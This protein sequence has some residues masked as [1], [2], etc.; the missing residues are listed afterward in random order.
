MPTVLKYLC[1]IVQRVNGPVAW[2]TCDEVDEDLEF[3]CHFRHEK[4][5]ADHSATKQAELATGH[6]TYDFHEKVDQ[7]AYMLRSAWCSYNYDCRC[8]A[9][10]ISFL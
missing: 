4:G 10:Q 3:Q 2:V 8:Y 1:I 9:C 7:L 6:N 5:K